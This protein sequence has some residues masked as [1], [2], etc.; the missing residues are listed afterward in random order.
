MYLVNPSASTAAV[1]RRQRRLGQAARYRSRSKSAGKSG[2]L[3]ALL[4]AYNRA[5]SVLHRRYTA[6]DRAPGSH[7]RMLRREEA[8]ARAI[9]R[10][11]R[12]RAG[13]TGKAGAK[14]TALERAHKRTHTRAHRRGWETFAAL[15]RRRGAQRKRRRR[16]PMAKRRTR[17]QIAAFRR[18]IAGLRRWKS[19]RGRKR[20]K[21]RARRRRNPSRAARA[22]RAAAAILVTTKP[23]R[24]KTMARR[25]RR[26]STAPHTHRRRRRRINGRRHHHRR[27]RHNPGGMNAG[28]AIKAVGK[29]LIPAVAGGLG[30]GLLDAKVTGGMSAPIRVGAKLAVAAIGGALLRKNPMRAAAFMGAMVGTAAYEAG[31]R[32]GG[33]VIAVSKAQGMHE[34]AALAAE[35][36]ENLGLLHESLAGFGLLT[37]MSG[38]DDD[39]TASMGDIEPDLGDVEPDLGEGEELVAMEELGDDEDY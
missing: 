16:N 6:E 9:A 23:R 34:L 2:K 19:G 35:D 7:L 22:R 11:K 5:G 15:E 24:R 14:L 31:V 10:R 37:D 29:A 12:V 39:G 26:R 8:L 32:V 36:D 38:D 17:K 18:M 25:R 28:A 30:A 13:W 21:S 33:G 4:A 27:R 1:Q 20:K 3:A